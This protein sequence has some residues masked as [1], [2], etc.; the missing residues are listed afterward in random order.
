M[1]DGVPARHSRARRKESKMSNQEIRYRNAKKRVEAL[2]G[3]YVHL[4][5]YV[6]V[7]LLLFTINMLTSPH[8][9]WFFW[10]LLGWGIAVVLHALRVFGFGHRF[11]AGW[12]ERKI[13]ELMEQEENQ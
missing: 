10:P 4:T 11:G 7:N 5:V 13:N 9:L 8:S 6:L 3:F 2:R 1:R 12:E